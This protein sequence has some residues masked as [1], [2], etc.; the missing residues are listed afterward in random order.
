MSTTYYYY[1]ISMF[2]IYI[3]AFSAS[4]LLVGCQEE[5]PGL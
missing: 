4:T 5:H 3:C 1:T 2:Y